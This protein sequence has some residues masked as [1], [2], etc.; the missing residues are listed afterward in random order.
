[1]S[2]KRYQIPVTHTATVVEPWH[3]KAKNMQDAMFQ[4]GQL[5][6]EEESPFKCV[7]TEGHKVEVSATP[8]SPTIVDDTDTEAET[9]TEAER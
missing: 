3:V 1:M 2:M 9:A 7:E 8:G 6:S 4:L 5:L